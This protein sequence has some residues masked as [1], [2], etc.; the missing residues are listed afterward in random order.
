[1]IMGLFKGIDEVVPY[2]D[3]TWL[4]HKVI[5]SNLANAD[6]PHYKELNVR[7]VPFENELA[8]KITDPKQIQP[9]QTGPHFDILEKESGLIGNDRNNVS[10]EKQMA[11]ANANYIAYET[12]MKMIT[13]NVNE[14]NTA[15]KGQ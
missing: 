5:L 12:Y 8:L 7:F 15:I 4:K 6:T 10:V 9:V 1:M 2:V 11:Q 3:Y 13:S 14:L